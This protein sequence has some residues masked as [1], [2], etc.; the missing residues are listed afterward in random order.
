M[1]LGNGGR[2]VSLFAGASQG[3]KIDSRYKA[4]G[5]CWWRRVVKA[6]ERWLVQRAMYGLDTS[7]YGLEKRDTW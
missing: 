4:P 7:P 5:R 6:S 2:E 3:D 1:G